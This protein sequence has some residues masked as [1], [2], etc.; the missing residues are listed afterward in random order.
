LA[1]NV[2][3]FGNNAPVVGNWLQHRFQCLADGELRPRAGFLPEI[4][5][6]PALP[7]NVLGGHGGGVACAAPVSQSNSRNS[8]HSAF[9]SIARR[10]A[11]RPGDAAPVFGL[12]FRPKVGRDN[13]NGNPA[14]TQ[15]EVMQPF[16]ENRRWTLCRLFEHG[17]KSS[18]VVSSN[19]L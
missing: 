15:G 18:A 9:F 17:K 14:Q 12:V 16:Q 3:S 19:F 5:N 7:V 13:R 8:F 4:G 2:D 1:V 6:R 10:S 11:V